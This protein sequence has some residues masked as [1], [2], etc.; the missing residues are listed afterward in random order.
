MA[1]TTILAAAT[2]GRKVLSYIEIPRVLKR[3]RE[4]Y[5]ILEGQPNFKLHKAM[6][7]INLLSLGIDLEDNDQLNILHYAFMAAFL[8]K[9]EV[10]ILKSY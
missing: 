5:S 3:M 9:E 4:E 7:A 6:L 2:I 10:P 8:V 1:I